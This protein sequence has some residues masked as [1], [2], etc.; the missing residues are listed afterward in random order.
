MQ[1]AAPKT[2]ERHKPETF[3]RISTLLQIHDPRFFRVCTYQ[4]LTEEGR[5][6]TIQPENSNAF[7]YS[8]RNWLGV[9]YRFDTSVLYLLFS[10][11][12]RAFDSDAQRFRTG[13][14][15]LLLLPLREKR[16]V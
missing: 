16:C 13:C 12:C 6:G 7:Q 8:S 11:I 3:A 5:A 15:P 10:A 14:V 9:L 2:R 4:P 1:A